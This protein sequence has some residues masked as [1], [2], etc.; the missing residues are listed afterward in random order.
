V[1]RGL[2]STAVGAPLLQYRLLRVGSG[3]ARRYTV[4]SRVIS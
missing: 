3:S 2:R 1:R 4:E